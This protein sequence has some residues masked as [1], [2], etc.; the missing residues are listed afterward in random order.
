[1]M[2]GRKFPLNAWKPSQDV[3]IGQLIAID[4]ETELIVDQSFPPLVLLQVTAGSRVDLVPY[5]LAEEYLLKLV[6]YNP[7]SKYVFVNAAYDLGVLGCGDLYDMIDNG[8]IVDMMDRYKLWEISE[9]GFVRKPASLAN[10]AR[11]VLS[12]KLDKKEEVR[13]TFTRDKSP[14]V[15]QLE[16]GAKDVVATW[17]LGAEMPEM[18][19]EADSQIM[20]SVVL[21]AISRNGMLV[22]MDH[23]HKTRAKFEKDFEDDLD[24]LE[25]HGYN[26]LLSKTS[27]EVLDQAL[28]LLGIKNP[29]VKASPQVYEY[30]LYRALM[31]QYLPFDD[32]CSAVRKSI[33]ETELQDCGPLCQKQLVEMFVMTIQE[34]CNG[35]LKRDRVARAWEVVKT[36]PLVDLDRFAATA[37]IDPFKPKNRKLLNTLLRGVLDDRFEFDDGINPPRMFTGIGLK[38]MARDKKLC[39]WPMASVLRELCRAKAGRIDTIKEYSQAAFSQHVRSKAMWYGNYSTEWAECLSPTAFMQARLIGIEAKNP[40]IKFPRTPKKKIQVSSKDKWIFKKFGIQDKLVETYISYKHNE[41]ILSTYLNPDYVREDGRVHTRFENYVRTGRTSSSGPN[42]QNVPGSGGIRQMYIPRP[43]YVFASIDYSQLEL[44]SLAQHC[45]REYGHSRM[46]E[47]INARIDLH[48]WFAGKTMGLITEENDYDGTPESRE[49]L[50]PIIKDIKDNQPK[51][52]Q[53]AKACNFG[54][55]GGMQ[56]KTFLSTQRGYGNIDIT[57][58]ECGQ[59]RANWF[60]AFPEMARHMEPMSD[61]V[62]PSD[63]RRFDNP[64]IRLY[65]A[66]NIMGVKRR[67]CTFNSA[68]NYPFQSLAALGAKRALWAVW[69]DGRYAKNMVNFIHDEIL[70]ELPA[71]TASEDVLIIQK[72]MED[73]MKEV[74]PDVR[75]EAE[76]CLMERW[77]KKAE[78]VFDEL[79]NLTV[80]HPE[81]KEEGAA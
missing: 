40:E 71:E 73:A 39:M 51:K 47:L 9:R 36:V 45:F 77:D 19:T 57:V 13:L 70:F 74:I 52:R 54:F 35:K 21:D 29:D 4:T 8:N 32:F 24:Y 7:D 43:M 60:L 27:K 59:L 55:P 53:D 3:V 68:C 67:K 50:M 22:D 49:R 10:M 12:V 1:M 15:G 66:H 34:D 17:L 62:T 46:M 14:S 23:F 56:E 31:N 41:K 37:R 75:I 72:I 18:P 63:R 11:N 61:V 30:I 81:K 20:G 69:R 79:G 38:E 5:D 25:M 80:W 64:N 48:S 65:V 28:E 76:G 78:P 42:I 6:R 16:Y 26:P 44:C 58:E 33:K 2:C